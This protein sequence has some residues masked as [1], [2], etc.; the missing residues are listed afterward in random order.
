MGLQRSP[1]AGSYGPCTRN[2]YFW[3]GWTPGRKACQTNASISGRRMRSSL[4][5]SSNR[6]SSTFSA[7]SLKIA[8]F[9]PVPSYVAPSG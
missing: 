3:P 4:P 2:P 7:A 9:V 5:R 8:K 1:W 6:H